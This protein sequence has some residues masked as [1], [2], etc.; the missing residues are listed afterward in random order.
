[1]SGRFG[2]LFLYLQPVCFE[3]YCSEEFFREHRLLGNARYRREN[4]LFP[5]ASFHSVLLFDPLNAQL[6]QW[7]DGDVIV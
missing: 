2:I 6:R 3:G 7:I 5:D 4:L 1:M